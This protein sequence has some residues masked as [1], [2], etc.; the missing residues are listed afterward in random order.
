MIKIIPINSEKS[1]IPAKKPQSDHHPKL[2]QAKG[3][4]RD[5]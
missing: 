5:R 4:P 1:Q 2:L 3:T